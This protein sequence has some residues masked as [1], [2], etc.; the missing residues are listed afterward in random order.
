MPFYVL[1]QIYDSFKRLSCSIDKFIKCK[2][3]FNAFMIPCKQLFLTN[4]I[5]FFIELMHKCIIFKQNK[6]TLTCLLNLIHLKLGLN[7]YYL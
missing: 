1:V 5:D 3:F 4:N 6:S 7:S 2:C